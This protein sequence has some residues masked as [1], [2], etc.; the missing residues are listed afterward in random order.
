MLTPVVVLSKEDHSD[1]QRLDQNNKFI[2]AVSTEE[3]HENE[4]SIT[5]ST[6][7]EEEYNNVG[8]SDKSIENEM[9]DDKYESQTIYTIQI[10]SFVEIERAEKQFDLIAQVLDEKELD[11][12]RI[13]KIGDFYTIRIGKYEDPFDAEN[14]LITVQS[15]LPKAIMLNAYIKD[16]RT[17]RLHKN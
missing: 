5:K 11:Y 12:L 17:I 13:E 15:H 1:L 8:N 7:L 3:K 10:G 4:L 6:V 9:T 16:N 14:F 2:Q